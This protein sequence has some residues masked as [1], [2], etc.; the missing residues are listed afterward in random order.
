MSCNRKGFLLWAEAVV[1]HTAEADIPEEDLSEG[2]PAADS[3]AAA[4][5]RA[6]Q[7]LADPDRAVPV[8][9]VPVL[10]GPDRAVP[11]L[12]DRGSVGR[13]EGDPYSPAADG[14][15]RDGAADAAVL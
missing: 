7:V 11:V 10:V 4:E 6:D 2:A 9:V 15:D 13:A 8:S 1:L 14:A 3:V 12:A 5:D